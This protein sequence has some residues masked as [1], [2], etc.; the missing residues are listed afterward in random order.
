MP[1]SWGKSIL[2][3]KLN[4]TSGTVWPDRSFG[5]TT[6]EKRFSPDKPLQVR[7]LSP[8]DEFFKNSCLVHGLLPTLN[9]VNPGMD[10][11]SLLREIKAGTVPPFGLSNVANSH[12]RS[13][14]GQE[15]ISS[16]GR[17]TVKN[18]SILLQRRYG[19]ARLTFA[20]LTL[21]T[22]S[23]SDNT[24]VV[25]AWSE[26]LRVFQQWLTRRLEREG[27]P[28]YVVGVSEIQEERSAWQ[29]GNLGLH[30]HF[31]FVGR[32]KAR[33]W[34]FTPQEIR[35]QWK[36]C[37]SKYLSVDPETVDWRAVENLQQVKKDVGSYLG[38]YL[39]KGVHS[40][41]KF[42]LLYPEK[43][44]PKSWY[45]CTNALRQTLK[46]CCLGGQVA[47]KEIQAAIE[48]GKAEW[49]ERLAFATYLDSQGVERI[50]GYYGRLSKYGA[51]Q[52]GLDSRVK[53]RVTALAD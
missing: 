41:R 51:Q 1:K 7:E 13:P 31:V 39:S 15:G 24:A 10:S 40:I 48:S 53:M 3:D 30:L 9:V 19:K 21:P 52:L 28:P 44:L 26:I 20:T 27:L 45:V 32:K 8:E 25:A 46:S 36:K 14:R 12:S 11:Y 33:S 37:V 16:K 4:M 50:C 23:D 49:F 43:C 42:R 29:E 18:A 35:N 2:W 47:A 34:V 38:K 5:V 17:A 6:L 22:L